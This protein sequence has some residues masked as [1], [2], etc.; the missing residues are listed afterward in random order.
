MPP[1]RDASWH[2]YVESCNYSNCCPRKS[3]SVSVRRKSVGWFIFVVLFFVTDVNKKELWWQRK[4]KI[5]KNQNLETFIQTSVRT[6]HFEIW[7][8]FTNRKRKEQFWQRS[9][10]ILNLLIHLCFLSRVN[11]IFK[12]Q[13]HD[14][15]NFCCHFY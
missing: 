13:F 8:V 11:L 14:E 12:I 7:Y 3:E 6:E 1:S 10:S 5:A 4:R 15:L 9:N 2:S